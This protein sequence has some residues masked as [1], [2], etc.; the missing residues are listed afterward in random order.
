MT[1]KYVDGGRVT[2]QFDNI[3]GGQANTE[4]VFDGNH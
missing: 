1:A 3:R 4:F 2:L